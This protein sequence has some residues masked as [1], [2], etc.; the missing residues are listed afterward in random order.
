MN[1]ESIGKAAGTVWKFLRENGAQ[2][3]SLSALKKVQGL[4][5]DDVMTAIGW[6]AREGKL[7]FNNSPNKVT[8]AL[9]E[10]EREAVGQS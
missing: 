8:V 6:L 10:S 2:G 7:R 3:V 4:K 9:V 1:E 5:A